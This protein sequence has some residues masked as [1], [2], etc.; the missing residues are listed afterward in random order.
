MSIEPTELETV[1]ALP[2]EDRYEFFLDQVIETGR[3]YGLVGESWAIFRDDEQGYQ[4][5]PVWSDEDFAHANAVGEWAG[6]TAKEF[7]IKDFS[8]GLVPELVQANMHLS[9]FKAP[10]DIGRVAEPREVELILSSKHKPKMN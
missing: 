7:T 8:E 1:I 5:F 2:A 10:N 6:Y 9:I 4:L 3:I